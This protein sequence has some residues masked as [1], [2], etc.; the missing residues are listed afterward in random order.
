MIL[1]VP[2]SRKRFRT[3]PGQFVAAHPAP[4]TELPG[5]QPGDLT[6]MPQFQLFAEGENKFFAKVADILRISCG[7]Y[8]VYS[9][10]SSTAFFQV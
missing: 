8:L 7:E 10:Q 9:P 3:T 4:H 5:K 6:G 2:G 1:V